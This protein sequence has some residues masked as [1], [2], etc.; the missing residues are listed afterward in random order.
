MKE[1]HTYADFPMVEC[2]HCGKTFQW[3]EYWDV[4]DG[5]D[6]ECPKCEKTIYVHNVDTQITGMLSTHP[7]K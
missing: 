1:K 2:P 3:E 6:A 5:D 4:Q 7:D